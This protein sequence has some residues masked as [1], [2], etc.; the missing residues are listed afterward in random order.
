VNSN[1]KRYRGLALGSGLIVL[2]LLAIAVLVP[3]DT[4]IAHRIAGHE[5]T[6]VAHLRAIFQQQQEFR[7]AHNGNFAAVLNEL[8]DAR[9]SDGAY[10][11]SLEVT[12]RDAQ[13]LVSGYAAEAHPSKPG[14]T[15]TRFFQLDQSGTLHFE[16]MHPVN[17][18]SP[19]R[20]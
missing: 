6:A 8:R 18:N 11:Y 1:G 9:F 3:N 5:S 2:L 13:G 20:E 10:N 19:V 16:L 7:A 12:A 4:L 15:G 17:P 14:E